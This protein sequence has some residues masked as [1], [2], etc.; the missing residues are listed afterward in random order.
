MLVVTREENQSIIIS[1]SD[2]PIT[3]MI[4]RSSGPIR[5]GVKAPA[6]CNVRREEVRRYGVVDLQAGRPETSDVPVPQNSSERS[7]CT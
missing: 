7:D 6:S 4:V 1:T 2:G 3:V 5:V